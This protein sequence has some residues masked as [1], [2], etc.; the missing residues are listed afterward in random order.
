L[1]IKWALKVKKN[2]LLKKIIKKFN[3]SILCIMFKSI[4]NKDMSY[5]DY[6]FFFYKV[7]FFIILLK[8]NINRI[9]KKLKIKKIKKFFLLKKYKKKL[10]KFRKLKKIKKINKLIMCLKNNK[11]KVNYLIFFLKYFSIFRRRDSKIFML[12]KLKARLSKKFFF[13]KK[14]KLKKFKNYFLKQCSNSKLNQKKH[15][16]MANLQTIFDTPKRFDRLHRLYDIK[17]KYIRYLSNNRSLYKINKF[18]CKHNF[19]FIKRHIRA[20]STLSINSRVH[21]YEFSLRNIIIKLKYAYTYRNSSFFI[22]SGFVFLNGKQELNPFFFLY[23]GDLIEL[24]F[25]KFIFKLKKK[26][27]KKLKISMRNYKRYNWRMLKHKVEFNTRKIRISRF[28]DKIL[29][30]KN[31]ISRIFQFDFRTLTFFL[32]DKL[33]S[34]KSLSYLNKKTLPLYLLKLFNW[35]LI[36]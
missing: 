24:I 33:N 1:Y 6:M 7:S 35:K 30:Y 36:S 21:M 12:A 3:Y 23:K 4:G 26:I 11:F 14:Y 19:K 10:K 20:V 29:H 31:K 18:R 34:K 28:A 2:K 25:S 5:K 17:K 8:K 32:I 27:K 22:K 13:K 16:D 9:K 15:I